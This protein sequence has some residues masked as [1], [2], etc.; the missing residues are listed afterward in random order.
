[1][2]LGED[3][4]LPEPTPYDTRFSQEAR[5]LRLEKEM[6]LLKKQWCGCRGGPSQSLERYSDVNPTEISEKKVERSCSPDSG[7]GTSLECRS[8]NGQVDK[9]QYELR[10]IV[11]HL[12]PE[13]ICSE[14]D[15]VLLLSVIRSGSTSRGTESWGERVAVL[16]SERRTLQNKLDRKHQECEE[17]KDAVADLKQ[18]LRSTQQQ[19]QASSSLLSQKREEVR[20]QLLLEESRTQKLQVRNGK[21]E[22]EIDRLKDMLHSHMR[23]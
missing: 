2:F 22:M 5:L 14:R 15:A 11:P 23:K 6:A 20:K 1:M 17:L 21:L 9:V 16:E 10:Q 18:K 19:A 8:D 3:D 13:F 12:S 7:L 4:D